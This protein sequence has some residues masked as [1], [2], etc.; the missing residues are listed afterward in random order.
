[1][2]ASNFLQRSKQRTPNLITVTRPDLY[3]SF[4]DMHINFIFVTNNADDAI[5]QSY[6][7]PF[8]SASLFDYFG[9]VF[10]AQ[11]VKQRCPS[12]STSLPLQ[13]FRLRIWNTFL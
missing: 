10:Y 13:V 5:Y 1:V 3:F 6:D 7:S 4:L 11:R 9:G 12:G 2:I 8:S